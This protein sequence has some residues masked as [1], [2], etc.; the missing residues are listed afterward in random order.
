MQHALQPG[1]HGEAVLKEVKEWNESGIGGNVSERLTLRLIQFTT[2]STNSFV[3]E[4]DDQYSDVNTKD[5]QSDDTY[6]ANIGDKFG[7][8]FEIFSCHSQNAERIWLFIGK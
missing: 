8:Y 5:S 1:S 2:S 7:W 6:F 3:S 4:T